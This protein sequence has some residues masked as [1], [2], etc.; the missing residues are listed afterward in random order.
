MKVTEEKTE[1]GFKLITFKDGYNKMCSMQESSA[2]VPHV[3]LGTNG[4]RMHLSKKDSLFL[5][6][7]LIK[8]GLTGRL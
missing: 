7:R 5:G 1:R 6:L 3:W 4:N 2:I 8:F